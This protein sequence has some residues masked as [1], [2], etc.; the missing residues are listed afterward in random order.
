[1]IFSY[2]HFSVILSFVLY[3]I[4][5]VALYF[6]IT[7]SY[8]LPVFQLLGYLFSLYF[9]SLEVECENNIKGNIV[10]SEMKPNRLLQ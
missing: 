5:N 3:I 10:L 1:M 9:L 4:I 6:N 2:L 8:D 7:Q